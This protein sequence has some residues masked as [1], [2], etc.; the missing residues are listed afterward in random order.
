MIES[1]IFDMDG[2]IFDSER[3]VCDLW[4]DFAKENGMSGMDE[5]IIKC[6]GINDNATKKLF[7][8]AY[9]EGC[10]Y[11]E[12]KKVISQKYH[13]LYDGGRLPMKP[14]V[15][16]LLGFLKE[17]DIKTAL[18]SSTKVK[19]VTNQLRDAGILEYFDVVIGGDMVTKSKPDPEIFLEAA[20]KL[21]VDPTKSF[22]IEDSLNGI[23]A[24]YAAG[25]K[26]LMVPDLIKPDEEIQ[27][28]CYNIFVNLHE[29]KA[30]FANFLH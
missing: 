24:A 23:K 25:A 7:L 21:G 17:N 6:I 8:E 22:I 12:Y 9:G 3:I 10:P 15:K 4:I 26:P 11:D 14:G 28:I 20:D 16:E 1:V 19:T 29:I 5:L 13:E 2:V 27:K 30:F 18:A